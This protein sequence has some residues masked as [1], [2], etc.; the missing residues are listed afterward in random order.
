MTCK[1]LSS[2]DKH[3]KYLWRGTDEKDRRKGHFLLDYLSTKHI[4]T[5]INK[6]NFIFNLHHKCVFCKNTHLYIWLH[7]RLER[8]CVRLKC[9]HDVMWEWSVVMM[10]CESEV[11]S[12]CVWDWWSVVMMCVRLVTC[13]HDDDI[14]PITFSEVTVFFVSWLCNPIVFMYSITP[15]A[16]LTV[17]GVLRVR[18]LCGLAHGES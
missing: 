11:F 15:D 9:C 16:C 14:I 12:W 1:V 4:W 17:A 8:C 5:N 6:I 13:L 2:E 3:H 7:F 18:S 10:L